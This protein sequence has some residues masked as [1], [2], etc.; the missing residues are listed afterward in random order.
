[1]SERCKTAADWLGH[2][3]V[4]CLLLSAGRLRRSAQS[5][6][7][8]GPTDYINM[9]VQPLELYIRLDVAAVV[10]QGLWCGALKVEKHC[11]HRDSFLS[12][13]S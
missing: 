2:F 6:S 1:M 7:S 5:A 13:R 4:A 9:P 3:L 10:A 11:E 12:E 8:S